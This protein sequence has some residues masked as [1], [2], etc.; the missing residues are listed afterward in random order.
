MSVMEL[1]DVVG[2]DRR[3]L[4]RGLESLRRQG[5]IDFLPSPDGSA[6][7]GRPSG[8]WSL[9]AHGAELAAAAK[10]R[11]SGGGG[12]TAD[13]ELEDDG[14]AGQL[15]GGQ[16]W[17]QASLDPDLATRI[18]PVIADAEFTAAASWIAVIE[19]PERR[20]FFV[21]EEDVGEQPA[22]NLVAALSASGARCSSGIVRRVA[23]PPE[24]VE[25]ARTSLAA[26]ERARRLLGSE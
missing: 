9:T 16:T 26:R 8:L 24:I 25:A 18:M 4:T 22:E 13:G 20:Y 23:A 17:V 6:A 19:G 2:G 1:R 12:T 7:P 14:F 21:F 10:T 3:T 15:R 5:L 11:S